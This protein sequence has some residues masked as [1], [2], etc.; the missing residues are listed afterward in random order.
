MKVD[1]TIIVA[2]V[3]G[4]VTILTTSVAGGGFIDRFFS[5]VVEVILAKESPNPNEQLNSYL[6]GAM[7]AAKRSDFESAI[8][9]LNLARDISEKIDS[10]ER[11]EDIKLWKVKATITNYGSKPATNLAL[12]FSAPPSNSFTTIS[13]EF[14][15]TDITVRNFDNSLQEEVPLQVDETIAMSALNIIPSHV[16][17]NTST[18]HHG[19]GAKI[20]LGFQVNNDPDLSKFAASAVYDQGSVASVQAGQ[21]TY[22]GF[23]DNFTRPS[24]LTILVWFAFII[25]FEYVL[26]QGQSRGWFKDKANNVRYVQT[27]TNWRI[28]RGIG[29]VAVA[30]ILWFIFA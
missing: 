12:S 25:L 27:N 1:P 28:I 24:I 10:A 9:Q 18:L 3:A 29:Y 15:T 23:V 5:P 16:E 21:P 19:T 4:S 14:S 7:T 20:D 26:L 8:I 6:Q 30:I 13:N 11:K 2:V 17:V 22:K